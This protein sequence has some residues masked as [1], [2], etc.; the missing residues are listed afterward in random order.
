MSRCLWGHCPKTER[1]GFPGQTLL[2]IL[3]SPKVVAIAEIV[4]M[5]VSEDMSRLL[6]RECRTGFLFR[7]LQARF[8][9]RCIV[10]ELW[11]GHL[12]RL[13][14]CRVVW[15]TQVSA[16]PLARPRTSIPAPKAKRYGMNA[17]GLQSLS[18]IA[19]RVRL[20][21]KDAGEFSVVF[22]REIN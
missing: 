14:P 21:C 12:G 7:G 19:Y 4:D 9:V 11:V 13:T 20:D 3:H 18:R 8:F 6:P 16:V 2:A 5:S 1:S 17:V 15:S 22:P 10:V